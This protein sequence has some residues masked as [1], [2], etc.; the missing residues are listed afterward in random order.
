[1]ATTN[2]DPPGVLPGGMAGPGGQAAREAAQALARVLGNVARYAVALGVGG[3]VL[4]S[5]M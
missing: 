5:S 1:M 3:S 4:Q 2:T